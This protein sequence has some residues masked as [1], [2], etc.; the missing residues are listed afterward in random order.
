M[1]DS[2]IRFK[3]A[4]RAWVIAPLRGLAGPL[5]NLVSTPE[6]KT[7]WI[8]VGALVFIAA[9]TVAGIVIGAFQGAGAKDLAVQPSAPVVE[10]S[11]E[12]PA[13][14][15]DEQQVV[16]RGNEVEL[17]PS[18]KTNKNGRVPFVKTSSPG[19]FAE[20][21]TRFGLTMDLSKDTGQ[22]WLD[23][24]AQW[25]TKFVPV[26]FEDWAWTQEVQTRNRSSVFNV[27]ARFAAQEAQFSGFST[28]ISIDRELADAQAPNSGS[29]QA[30]WA[31][32][33][34]SGAGLHLIRTSWVA[35]VFATKNGSTTAPMQ[36]SSGITEMLIACPGLVGFTEDSCKIVYATDNVREAPS[37]VLKAW[38]SR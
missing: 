21:Y 7:R 24:E 31:A 16:F 28:G 38:P 19:E 6:G 18:K 10:P 4:F 14:S 2:W 27:W 5:R 29:S 3:V 34:D 36:Q 26:G 22:E 9:V 33:I 25:R 30:L 37:S 17:N 20:A 13:E 15:R 35:S 11:Q 23:A 8:P 32:H 12:V 1:R